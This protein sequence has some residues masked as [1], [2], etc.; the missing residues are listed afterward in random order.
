MRCSIPKSN[1]KRPITWVEIRY[2]I[3]IEDNFLKF[4]PY[5]VWQGIQITSDYKPNRQVFFSSLTHAFLKNKSWRSFLHQLT[6]HWL[7]LPLMSG[8]HWHST[9]GRRPWW[10]SCSQS[11]YRTRLSS[12]FKLRTSKLVLTQP[13][14]PKFLKYTNIFPVPKYVAITHLWKSLL[15]PLWTHPTLNPSNLR[16]ILVC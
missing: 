16:P 8:R 1:L 15:H 10:N 7:P 9:G 4:G 14:V 3:K 2:P 6:R 12:I 13:V 11:V 5:H